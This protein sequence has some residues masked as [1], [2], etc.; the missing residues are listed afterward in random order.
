MLCT[1]LDFEAFVAKLLSVD[2]FSTSTVPLGEVATLSHEARNN[3]M[4]QTCL[5]VE[6]LTGLSSACL[7]RAKLPE[8]LNS[9][10]NNVLEEFEHNSAFRLV[11]NAYVEVDSWIRD[12]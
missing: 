10:W 7:P 11:S 2:T 9:S 3:A 12:T 5:E 6:H 4:K 1:V 8:V